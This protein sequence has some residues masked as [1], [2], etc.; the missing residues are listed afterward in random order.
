MGAAPDPA[1]IPDPTPE[2]K[3]DDDVVPDPDKIPEPEPI[4][5]PEPI[6]GPDPI[7][8]PVDE[9]IY[10][11]E[12]PCAL[13]TQDFCTGCDC[14]MSWPIGETWES[15]DAACRCYVEEIIIDPIIIEP[16]VIIVPDVEPIIVDPYVEYEWSS[17]CPTRSFH[18]CVDCDCRYSW[19][20]GEDYTSPEARCRCFTEPVI[21]EPIIEPIIVEPV[22][23]YD[24]SSECPSRFM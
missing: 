13:P 1:D 7:I 23:E 16:D 2:P 4:P 11:Y 24:W 15:I 20:I 6:P 12:A 22:I 3:D 10:H 8:E 18:D 5:Q 14:R 9:V 17:Q 19:P 21:I